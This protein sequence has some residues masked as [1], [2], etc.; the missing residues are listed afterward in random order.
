MVL[1]LLS[2][3]EGREHEEDNHDRSRVTSIEYLIPLVTTSPGLTIGLII[4]LIASSMLG[5]YSTPILQCTRQMLLAV[6]ATYRK[7]RPK[8]R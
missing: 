4:L 1:S 8:S 6:A 2:G 5:M 3:R 7:S